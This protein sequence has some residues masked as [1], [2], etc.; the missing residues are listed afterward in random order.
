MLKI[1]KDDWFQPKTLQPANWLSMM[2]Q[3]KVILEM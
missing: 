2:A 3:L 1:L